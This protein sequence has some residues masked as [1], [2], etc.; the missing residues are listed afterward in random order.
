MEGLY[1]TLN[2]ASELQITDKKQPK[3]KIFFMYLN[4]GIN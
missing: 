4:F 1:C 3:I 2:W